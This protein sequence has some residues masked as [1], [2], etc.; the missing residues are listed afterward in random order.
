M[1]KDTKKAAPVTFED[2]KGLIKETASAL[3]G[4]LSQDDLDAFLTKYDLDDESAEELLAFITDSNI[5][6]EDGL[7]TLELDDEELL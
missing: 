3:G 1:K 7:D 6:I 4:V 2:L 5:T